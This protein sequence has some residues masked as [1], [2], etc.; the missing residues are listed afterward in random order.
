MDTGITR[1][2]DSP[3][4]DSH[5]R[6]LRI[7]VRSVPLPQL[8]LYGVPKMLPDDFE[9]LVHHLFGQVTGDLLGHMQRRTNGPGGH[10]LAREPHRSRHGGVAGREGG[11]EH[12][13][14]RSSHPTVTTTLPAD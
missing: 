13:T 6:S 9:R 8:D 4:F 3:L 10:D 14:G 12:R 11:G 2:G 7:A 5:R 1:K